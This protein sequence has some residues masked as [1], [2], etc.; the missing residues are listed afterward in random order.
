MN[1]K[2][3]INCGD[4]GVFSSELGEDISVHNLKKLVSRQ[5]NTEISNILIFYKDQELFDDSISLKEAGVT[6]Y[7][8][9]LNVKFVIVKNKFL[10]L[11]IEPNRGRLYYQKINPK[12]RL[13]KRCWLR[14]Y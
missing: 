6:K 12:Y 1:L 2:V 11:K 9:S 5:L 13:Q 4:K 7:D 14:R 8:T 3:W 10:Y